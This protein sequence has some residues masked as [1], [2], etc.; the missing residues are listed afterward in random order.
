MNP[1][2]IR[3][4]IGS[5]LILAIGCSDSDHRPVAPGDQVSLDSLAVIVAPGVMQR[6]DGLRNFYSLDDTI[7][8][9]VSFINFD[10]WFPFHTFSSVEPPWWWSIYPLHSNAGIFHEPS[11]LMP[12]FW[13]YDLAPGD[14]L[15]YNLMWDLDVY[16]PPDGHPHLQ[17]LKAF[18]GHYLLNTALGA[19]TKFLTKHIVIE[20]LGDPLSSLASSRFSSDSIL[21]DLVMRNRVTVQQE[22]FLDDPYPVTVLFTRLLNQRDTALSRSFALPY[23]SIMLPGHRDTVLFSFK[24]S[25]TDSMFANLHGSYYVGMK[26]RM[27]D[28]ELATIQTWV[29]FPIFPNPYAKSSAP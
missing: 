2:N 1:K 11:I 27:R 6:L 16:Y 26:L 5:L 14:T 17:Y 21:I 4:K 12:S 15:A 9:S 22:H 7:T 20:E 13:E 8:W 19:N 10:S 24:A 29:S 18:S 25:K 23:S 3:L 28:R